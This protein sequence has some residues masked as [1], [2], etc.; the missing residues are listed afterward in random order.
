MGRIWSRVAPIPLLSLSVVV[1][2][3][4]PSTGDAQSYEVQAINLPGPGRV[5][6]D[7]AGH[8][9][10]VYVP[11]AQGPSK[12]FSGC[13]NAWP[14]LIL[15]YGIRHPVGGPGVDDALLGTTRRQ[16]GSLQ[17]TYNRWPLYLYIGDGRGQATGQAE[18][19][20]SW[21]LLSTSG[22]VDQ[23]PVTGPVNT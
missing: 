9:L 12:C 23:R 11:D 6:A 21:Y 3:C 13:A 17:V 5:L 22:A 16:N 2:A 18:D 8:V 7:G 14:P 20:G 4:G 15:P 1:A 19:M 10:Y